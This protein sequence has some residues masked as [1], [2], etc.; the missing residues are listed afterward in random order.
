MQSSLSLLAEIP[1][2]RTARFVLPYRHESNTR[3][4][5]HCDGTRHRLRDRSTPNART[6]LTRVRLSECLRIELAAHQLHFDT[7]RRVSL[8]YKG[9]RIRSELKLDLVVEE[10]VVVEL[11]SVGAIPSRS[12][13]PGDH[14]SEAHRL[15]SG[16]AYELQCDNP[17]SRPEA[18]GSSRQV[19][20]EATSVIAI[21]ATLNR[22][23]GRVSLSPDLLFRV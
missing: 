11:K 21:E 19:R 20:Q 8:T 4:S 5:R 3:R 1:L 2:N 6:R 9:Q 12:C 13:R 16:T 14:V 22:R 15:S 17:S 23:P 18:S 10:S 7:D